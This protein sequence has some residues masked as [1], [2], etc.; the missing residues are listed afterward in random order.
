MHW[1]VVIG[2]QELSKTMEGLLSYHT[3]VL[4]ARRAADSIVSIFSVPLILL[5]VLARL[6][7]PW[8]NNQ[9]A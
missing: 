3:T 8:E 6:F 7:S 2:G 1:N 9:Q 4:G 5:W